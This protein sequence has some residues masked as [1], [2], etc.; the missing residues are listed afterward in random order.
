MAGKEGTVSSRKTDSCCVGARADN[1]E[2]VLCEKYCRDSPIPYSEWKAEEEV[3][4][5]DGLFMAL[6]LHTRKIDEKLQAVV[7]NMPTSASYVSPG[8]RNE[9]ISILGSMVVEHIAS[10]YAISEVNLLCVKADKLEM[11]VV[12]K[13]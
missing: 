3:L 9:V 2:Q 13:I 8:I 4:S 1:E 5:P 12:L 10:L 6:F 7:Q 11:Q